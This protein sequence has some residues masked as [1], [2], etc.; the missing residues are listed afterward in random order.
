MSLISPKVGMSLVKKQLELK[1][2][3]K[4]DEFEIYYVPAQNNLGFRVEGQEIAFE[5]PVLKKLIEEQ[6]D[7]LQKQL[8]GTVDVLLI[9]CGEE[10][11]SETYYTKD[12]KKLIHKQKV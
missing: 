8:G 2:N 10:I 9:K 6:K 12:E 11:M 3:K 7:V 4:I 1:L 5:Q